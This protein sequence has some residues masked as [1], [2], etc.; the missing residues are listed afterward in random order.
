[1]CCLSFVCVVVR[2]VFFKEGAG[3]FGSTDG[4]SSSSCEVGLDF[5]V[6]YC[7]GRGRWWPAIRFWGG[8]ERGSG[9]GERVGEGGGGEWHGLCIPRCCRAFFPAITGEKENNVVSFD[10]FFGCW[11]WKVVS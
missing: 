2:R 8:G 1:M 6:V 11:W 3:V 7:L 4:D 10:L 9:L 5:A